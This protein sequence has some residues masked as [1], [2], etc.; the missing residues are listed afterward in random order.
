MGNNLDLTAE[1]VKELTNYTNEIEKKID[2]AAEEKTKELVS[3]L[4]KTS[5]KSKKNGRKKYAKSWTS[6]KIG[7]KHVV[8]NKKYQLT[9]LL[10]YGHA[11]VNGGRVEGKPH[12]KPAEEKAN[13]EFLDEVERVIEG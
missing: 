4:K 7:N 3:E 5:P 12:I 1:I 9:H 11:K 2:N 13:K 6:K 10:E 8:Y